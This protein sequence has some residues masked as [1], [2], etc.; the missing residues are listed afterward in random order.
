LCVGTEAEFVETA[1]VAGLDRE[2]TGTLEGDYE[3]R[4]W[5]LEKLGEVKNRLFDSS[6]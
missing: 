5:L 3:L 6:E 1:N 2:L 4:F